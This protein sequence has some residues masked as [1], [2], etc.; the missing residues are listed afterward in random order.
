MKKIL[1]IFLLFIMLIPIGV[2]AKTY[3]VNDLDLEITFSD[4]WYVFTRENLDDNSD[5]EYLGITKEYMETIFE[6]AEAYIDAAPKD[7]S[8]E[9]FLRVRNVEDINNLNNYSDKDVEELAKEVA[10]LVETKEYTT[11][12]NDYKYV[13]TK[14]PDVLEGKTYD[15]ISYY[16]IV[17]GKGY[18]FTLQKESE[19]TEE[20]ETI[21][22]NIID[23]VSYDFNEGYEQE[24]EKIENEESGSFNWKIIGSPAVIG[25]FIGGIVGLFIN[26][27][28]K[29]KKKNNGK[30]DYHEQ[31]K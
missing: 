11:Y 15:I 1:I 19:L 4:D 21:M 3:R 28:A 10:K 16:T 30:E 27:T 8:I 22:K 20:D 29:N 23:T 18:T 6:N 9:F 24:K 2:N 7:F 17:N 25:A 31:N 5:L 14:Y 12:K 13:I 26:K